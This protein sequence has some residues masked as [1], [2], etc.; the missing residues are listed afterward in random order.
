MRNIGDCGRMTGNSEVIP[1]DL[2]AQLL[3]GWPT[4]RQQSLHPLQA[5]NGRNWVSHLGPHL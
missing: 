5:V 4:I 2:F 3:S 1:G